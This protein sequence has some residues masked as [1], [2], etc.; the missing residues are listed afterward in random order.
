MENGCVFSVK[1]LPIQG[2]GPFQGRILKVT[3]RQI[4]GAADR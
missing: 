4:E 3:D 2:Y 1:T